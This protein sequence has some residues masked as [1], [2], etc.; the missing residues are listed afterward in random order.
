MKGLQHKQHKT[1]IYE[2]FVVTLTK[3]KSTN[4]N[5]DENNKVK[6]NYL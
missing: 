3:R 1:K 4:E 2:V 5:S 6:L